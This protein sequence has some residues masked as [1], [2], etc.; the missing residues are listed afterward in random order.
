MLSQAETESVLAEHLGTEGV[1]VERGT[2]LLRLEAQGAYVTCRLWRQDGGE[3]TVSARY[4]VGCDGADSTVRTAAGIGFRGYAYPQTFLLADVE[5]DGLERGAARTFMH[6]RGRDAVLLSARRARGFPL[7]EPATW[8]MLALRP[9]GAPDAE[10]T[11]GLMQEIVDRCT[12]EKLRLRDP[13]WMTDFRLHN[14]GATHYRAGPFFLAGDA[15][16]IHSPAG[17]QGMNTGMQDAL[18]LDLG[19]KLALV[20]RGA[21]PQELLDTYET[22]RPRRPQRPALHRPHLHHRHQPQPGHP[23]G[24]HSTRSVSRPVGAAGDRAA[25]ARLPSVS[26]LD[27]GQAW[28]WPG[29]QPSCCKGWKRGR[30]SSSWCQWGASGRDDDRS[31]LAGAAVGA[32]LRHHAAKAGSQEGGGHATC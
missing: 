20:C 8:R 24:P 29:C 28:M 26:E 15:A 25:Q 18:S 27:V 30:P 22:E 17:A 14:R 16:H 12:G 13:V 1:T 10:V 4:V 9:L 19:W 2:E 6:D 21:A 3:E 23:P 5:V 11:L 31:V 32:S 7:G